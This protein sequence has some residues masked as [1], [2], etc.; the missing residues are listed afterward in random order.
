MNVQELVDR[1]S[2]LFSL[3]EVCNRVNELLDEPEV[4]EEVIAEV[5]GHDPVLTALLLK[6][7]NQSPYGSPCQVDD[8]AEA[9]SRIGLTNLRALMTTTSAIDAFEQVDEDLVDMAD[10]WHHSVCCGIAA[11]SLAGRCGVKDTQTMFVAGLLHDIGQLVLYNSFPELAEQ[12]LRKAGESEYFRYRAE[13]EIMGVTHAQV[14]AELLRRWRL[15]PCL[16]EVVAFHHEPANAA[17]Y[18]WETSVVHIA[19]AVANRVEPSWKMDSEQ[20]NSPLQI[21]PEAW[22]VTGLSPE[23]ID[24]TVEAI[25]TESF[26]VMSVVNPGSLFLY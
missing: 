5:I 20:Q 2:S 18:G 7:A 13:Q 12:V 3:P 4:T 1:S 14:G 8:V 25:G 22:E 19:T 24:L 15:S 26:A 17:N 9:T 23:V 11:G 16:Q 21:Q 6:M 10:F